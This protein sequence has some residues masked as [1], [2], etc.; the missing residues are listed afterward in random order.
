MLGIKCPFPTH[1]VKFLDSFQ[2]LVLMFDSK[3]FSG[4]KL[5]ERLFQIIIVI[6]GVSLALNIVINPSNISHRLLVLSS[7]TSCN[8][9]V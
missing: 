7:V 2:F 5:A 6:F 4:Q 1:M 8:N 9:S 3:D